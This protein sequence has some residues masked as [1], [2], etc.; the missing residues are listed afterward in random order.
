[1]T[2][3]RLSALQRQIMAWLW[4]NMAKTSFTVVEN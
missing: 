1:M 2:L 4:A 3:E